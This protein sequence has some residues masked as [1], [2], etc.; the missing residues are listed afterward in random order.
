MAE[1][2]PAVAP[3][4]CALVTWATAPALP[5]DTAGSIGKPYFSCSV[6]IV[7]AR[8]GKALST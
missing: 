1:P 6:L 8:P 7:P 5:I 2:A 4:V 3:D